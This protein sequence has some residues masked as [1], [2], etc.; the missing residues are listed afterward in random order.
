M[1]A[2]EK[3]LNYIDGTWL[4]AQGGGFFENRNPASDEVLHL[5]ANSAAADVDAAAKA[6]AAAFPK[7][8]A[9]PAPKR[10]EILFRAAQ[11]LLERK[12]ELGREL[13]EEMGKV[14]K[15]GLG[16]VQEGIDMT[17]YM[18]GEGRRQFGETVPSELPDKW[19]MSVR[20]PVGI[21]GAIT[22]WN[23]PMA[24]PTWKLM[25]ALIT[26]NTVVFKPSQFSPRSAW[27]LVR[28]LEE[29]GLPPG[30][31]NLVFGEGAE[32]GAAVVDHPLIRLI[33]FT[34]SNAVGTGV[35]R[36][37]AELGKTCHLEM[38]GKNAITIL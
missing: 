17:Y 30:V 18:A 37:C 28:I 38:G 36:R 6:A 1:S 4:P 31:V 3:L 33:S 8:R 27:N 13:T 26:G 19:A 24:I 16:D 29:V 15:E 11:L 5:V 25:P 23:F 34:G 9:T 21:V 35:G 22:P 2:P 10:G 7:W 14:L 32:P 12:Q 20:M